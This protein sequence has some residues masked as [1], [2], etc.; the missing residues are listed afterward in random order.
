MLEPAALFA[1]WGVVVV[2]VLA[3]LSAALGRDA[4]ADEPR[5]DGRALDA[6]D[7]QAAA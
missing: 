7:D 4:R 3:G 1:V 2:G 5:V 6:R